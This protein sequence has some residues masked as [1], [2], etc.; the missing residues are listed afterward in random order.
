[1]H[2][3]SSSSF[4]N[5]SSADEHIVRVMKSPVRF[6]THAHQQARTSRTIQRRMQVIQDCEHANAHL[7]EDYFW[8]S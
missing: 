4:F 8:G 7:L 2:E 5:S 3:W 1:M 6:L